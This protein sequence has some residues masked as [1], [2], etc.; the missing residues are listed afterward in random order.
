MDLIKTIR[1]RKS[2]RAFKQDPI[3][4]ETIQEILTLASH[5]PSA[6][7]LQPWEFIVVKGEE[8]ER[9]SRRLIKAYKEKQISCGPGNVKPL[10]KTYAKRGA[11]TLELMNPF[12][13]EMKA[14]L[15]QFINEGSCNFYGAP[16]AIFICLDDSF[17]KARFVDIGLVLG[18]LLL[19]ANEYGLGTCPIGLIT[20]YEDE[21]KELLNIPENKIVV[22]GIALG[23][24]DLKNPINRFKSPREDI[25]NFIRWIE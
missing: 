17:P 13:E 3:P 4:K 20:A 18:Y 12:F 5:A 10:P 19:I 23:Y 6:I 24:P 15:N 16:T 7:N 11:K 21:I 14:D 8:R 25:G 22:I 9:L 1:E 2:F